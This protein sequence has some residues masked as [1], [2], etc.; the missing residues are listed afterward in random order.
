MKTKD[1]LVGLAIIVIAVV[2]VLI[3]G[4]FGAD[5]YGKKG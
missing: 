5:I 1:I 4:H 3:A 2:L